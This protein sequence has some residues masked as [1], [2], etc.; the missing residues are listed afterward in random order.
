MYVD[1]L[2]AWRPGARRTCHL[3]AD[4]PAELRAFV[5]RTGIPRH[6]RH[7]RASVPHYDLPE[8]WREAALL[9]GAVFVPAKEQARARVR[10]RS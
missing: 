1:E 9:L 6:Y 4:T 10:S 8:R 7:P 3:T 5:R 2:R